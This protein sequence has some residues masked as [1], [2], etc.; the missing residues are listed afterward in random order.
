MTTA[1]VPA[2]RAAVQLRLHV[3]RPHRPGQERASVVQAAT[4]QPARHL[5]DVPQPVDRTD[6]AQMRGQ[7]CTLRA[8]R[9]TDL[10]A[11]YRLSSDVS[12]QA[13]HLALPLRSEPSF[14]KEFDE[15]GFL[16]ARRGR[17]AVTDAADRL[18][19]T[20]V[21]F[22][23]GSSDG[24]EIGY[25]LF[26]PA[27]RNKGVM[28]EAVLLMVDYLFSRHKINRLQ[29][30]TSVDNEASKRLALKCG[31]RLERTVHAEALYH[32]RDRVWLLYAL[33]RSRAQ[34]R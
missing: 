12:L 27:G 17:L 24:F 11:L 25:H 29:I 4:A 19:G 13:E 22:D 2:V 5:G 7:R 21:Y 18:L 16:G 20:V 1:A 31:F 23:V 14:R 33:P 26:E 32:G 34:P 9:A 8:V 15:T 30:A 3:D 10:A 28:T 6:G